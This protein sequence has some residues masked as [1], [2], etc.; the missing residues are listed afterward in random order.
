MTFIP[1]SK[2]YETVSN[3]STIPLGANE[4]FTGIAEN[5][6]GVNTIELI[7]ESDEVSK[8][9]G[10][11]IQ[12]SKDSILWDTIYPYNYVRTNFMLNIPKNVDNKYFRIVYIN[13]DN[14][15]TIFYLNVIYSLNKYI[16]NNNIKIENPL[17]LFDEVRTSSR[18]PLISLK[19]TYGVS[20]LRDEV[21]TTGDG[22]VEN[23]LVDGGG[24]TGEYYLSSSELNAS[25]I[26]YSAERGRYQAG[27]GAVGGIGIR[28]PADVTLSGNQQMLWGLG[29][30]N[31]GFFFGKD[32]TGMFVGY[33]RSGA[34]IIKTYSANWNVD[35]LDGNGKSGLTLELESGNIFQINFAWYGYGVIEFVIFFNTQINSF[36]TTQ[37]IVNRIIINGST[38]IQNPNLPI[39]ASLNNGG[40]AGPLEMYVG[41]RQYSVDGLVKSDIRITADRRFALSVPSGTFL[42]LISF[43]R[44]A[45]YKS[46]S[47]KLDGY[48]IITDYDLVLEIRWDSTITGGTYVTPTNTLASET[49]IESNRA[50]TA[51]S[52]DPSTT[53][54]SLIWSDLIKG[55]AGTGR[56]KEESFTST[57]QLDL[58]LPGLQNVVIGV[59]AISTTA[60][61]SCIF[62]VRE[63][64]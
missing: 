42:P 44:K 28:I 8:I 24:G 2:N 61:V 58:E 38:S 4:T 60:T 22:S 7:I 3:K 12:Y 54:G 17:N 46:I 15:Q 14:P 64:W 57:N 56:N 1:S 40:T 49:A 63:E 41:G 59:V 13:G 16:Q 62:R 30:E 29:D 53:G 19:S 36:K 39:M 33:K 43:K 35:T 6:M 50:A 11:Q 31:Y 34:E 51:M 23:N 37:I 26:L 32:S 21:V 27:Y 20:K 52:V 55:G 18:T 9:N 47:I 45:S 25:S 5:V 10:V 48:S